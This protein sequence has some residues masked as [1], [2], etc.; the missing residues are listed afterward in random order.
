MKV[1]IKQ[2]IVSGLLPNSKI[3]GVYTVSE[4][5]G[6]HLIEIG[7]AETYETKIDRDY[8]PAKKPQ[9]SPSLVVGK[10]LE[11]LTPKSRKKKAASLPSTTP[12]K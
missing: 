12:G 9:S 2:R 7:A 3:G 5:F 8:E 11:K 6:R 10:V 4:E 1:K